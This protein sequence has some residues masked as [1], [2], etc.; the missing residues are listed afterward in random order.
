MVP[1][2]P[3]F[4]QCGG[5][6][7]QELAYEDQL[8]LKKEMVN[9][10]LQGVV[11]VQSVQPSRPYRYRNRMD[12]VAAFGKCGLRRQ[13]SFRSV[14]DITACHIMQESSEA[15]FRSI[16]PLVLETEGYDY[17]RHNGY[18]RYVVVREARF[19]G[20]VMMNFV[21]AAR[22]NRLRPLID[23]IADS[24]H[25][26]S[27]IFNSGLADVSFGEEFDTVKNGFI[28]ESFDGIRYRI[29]PNSFFQSNSEVALAMY[30]RIREEAEGKVLDL[31]AGVGSI[32]L[33]V[34]GKAESVTGVEMNQEAVDAA[35]AN[36]QANLIENAEFICT[37]VK[38]FLKNS[39]PGYDTIILDPPRNG[40]LPAVMDQV[41][42]LKA[43]KI[44]YMSCSPASFRD[45]VAA[46][47]N[48]KIE[49]LESYDMFPQTP[50]VELLCNLKRIT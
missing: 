49:S 23:S 26:I 14:V 1:A 2:C 11:T 18:L 5:C 30:R 24:A 43:R 7:F 3:H 17:I 21:T 47:G 19:T 50:H 16:R 40:M 41:N 4:G 42:K 28:E 35:S 10:A 32:S 9:D 6:L 25:S 22:E 44:I 48:Y 27:I 37:D 12:F 33:F 34:A 8:L 15:L 38:D 45:D 29:T 46:L 31:C 39:G 13:G 20:Q 36:K